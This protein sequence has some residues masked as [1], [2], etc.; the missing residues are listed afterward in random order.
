MTIV[1]ALFH[2]E[3]T[4][5]GRHAESTLPDIYFHMH[6]A[7][8]PRASKLGDNHKQRPTGSSILMGDGLPPALRPS[9]NPLDKPRQTA[10]MNRVR[11]EM[12]DLSR[13]G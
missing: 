13:A 4:G 10:T 8:I 9:G 5:E 12:H 6:E 1:S 2:Q 11:E 3:R 7:S